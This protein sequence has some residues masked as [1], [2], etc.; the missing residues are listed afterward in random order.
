M[1]KVDILPPEL[2]AADLALPGRRS[3]PGLTLA[4][5][6]FEPGGEEEGPA[7]VLTPVGPVL[8]ALLLVA[9]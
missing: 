2:F 1:K 6:M 9:L 4:P 7:T 3:G 8:A 5:V